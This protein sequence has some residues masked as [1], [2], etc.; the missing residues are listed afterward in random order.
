[1]I[2]L[3][4]HIEILLLDNDCVIVPDLGGFVA[5]QVSAHYDEDDHMWLPPVRTLGFNPQLQQNDSLLVQSYVNAYDISYPEAMRRL[6]DD[7]D[8][9]KEELDEE[10]IYDLHGIGRLMVNSDGNYEFE[11]FEAGILTPSYYGLGACQFLTLKDARASFAP[12]QQSLQAELPQELTVD[13]QPVSDEQKSDEATEQETSPALLEFTDDGKDSDIRIIRIRMSWVRNSVAI[14]AAIIAFFVMATP[15]ANSD[16]NTRTMS[17]LQNNVL[18]KLIPQDTNVATATPSVD[19]IPAQVVKRKAKT[20]QVAV[21]DTPKVVVK[22]DIEPYC[23][24]LA[25]RVKK[26]NAEYYVEQ[27][28]KR[29]YDQASIYI[30]NNVVRVVYGSFKNE[31]AAYQQLNNLTDKEEFSEAWVYKKPEV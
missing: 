30:H 25:S 15:I 2:E 11:P 12:Q 17:H 18:Y 16:L 20:E 19:T 14:A 27:L 9:L 5:Y 4:R 24:V 26:S 8:D 28:K 22:P 31:S 13:E 6:E 10:G 7:V 21:V 1:M 3:G 29:G 23:I